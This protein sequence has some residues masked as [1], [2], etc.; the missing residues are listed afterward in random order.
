[1]VMSYVTVTKEQA[2]KIQPYLNSPVPEHNP[3]RAEHY[4]A[5]ANLLAREIPHQI[6]LAQ[7]YAIHNGVLNVHLNIVDSETLAWPKTNAQSSTSTPKSL[8][9]LG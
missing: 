1:M 7:V 2:G 5:I 4:K 9:S 6:T 3:E 8:S